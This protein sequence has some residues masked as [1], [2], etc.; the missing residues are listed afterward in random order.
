MR[1]HGVN[2]QH[3]LQ[4]QRIGVGYRLA[5]RGDTGIVDQNADRTEI[6]QHIGDHGLVFLEIL[7]RGRIGPR[8][9]AELFDGGDGFLR[10][11]L[12]AAVVDGDIGAGFGQRDGDGAADAAAAAGHQRHAAFKRD[13]HC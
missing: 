4:L 7:D 3:A 6:L 1:R 9:A 5:A 11:F 8:L 2:L 13:V 12:V 10:G